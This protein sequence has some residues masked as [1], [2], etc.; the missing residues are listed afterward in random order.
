M[1]TPMPFFWRQLFVWFNTSFTLG[2]IVILGDYIY[3]C[4]VLYGMGISFN[5]AYSYMFVSLKKRLYVCKLY[6]TTVLFVC[7]LYLKYYLLNFK[8]FFCVLLL[9]ILA[10]LQL[11]M[12][13]MYVCIICYGSWLRFVCLNWSTLC[14]QKADR[15][16]FFVHYVF[17][18]CGPKWTAQSSCNTFNMFEKSFATLKI[19]IDWRKCGCFWKWCLIVLN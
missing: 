9:Q 3:Q 1:I 8:L 14:I 11:Y 7:H 18:L 13:F 16:R 4:H 15:K 19:K 17:V 10:L 2:R 5:T 12:C 6:I